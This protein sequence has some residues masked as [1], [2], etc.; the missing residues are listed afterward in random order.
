VY[1][2]DKSG[3][4]ALWT[5]VRRNIGAVLGVHVDPDGTHL[6]ATTAG[7]PQ[8]REYTPADSVIAALLKVRI[9]DGAIVARWDLPPAAAGHTL[10]DVTVT[11]TGDVF[12]SD[13]RE[14]VL[15]RLKRGATQLES[16]RDPLF[17]SLQGMAATPGGAGGQLAASAQSCSMHTVF[18]AAPPVPTQISPATMQS[19]SSTQGRCCPCQSTC[20][21]CTPS[22]SPQWQRLPGPH[23]C[24]SRS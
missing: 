2:H 21:H 7:I 24:C 8:M 13:S 22:V 3:T 17:R 16:F 20:C 1:V 14:P 9:A 23:A 4:R 10:G 12:T 5:H 15:Y 11:A 18:G 6:W 19:M